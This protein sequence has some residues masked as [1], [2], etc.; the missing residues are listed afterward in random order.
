MP[1]CEYG[2]LVMVTMA[3][4]PPLYHCHIN[5]ITTMTAIDLFFQ[6][7]TIT[8]QQNRDFIVVVHVHHGFVNEKLD[9]TG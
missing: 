5:T 2:E 8:K 6:Q 4:R 7:Q 9:H 3:Q 1:F